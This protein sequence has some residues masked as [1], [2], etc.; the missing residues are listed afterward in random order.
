MRRIHVGH[1]SSYINYAPEDMASH[2]VLQ[3]STDSQILPPKSFEYLD[4]S[5]FK[6]NL[7]LAGTN[8]SASW[9]LCFENCS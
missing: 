3:I 6:H 9:N 2:C 4:I 8:P 1:M 5:L 7:W